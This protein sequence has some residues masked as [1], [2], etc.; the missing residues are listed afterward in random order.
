MSLTFVSINPNLP[1]GY[2]IDFRV[3]RTLYYSAATDTLYCRRSDI[4]NSSEQPISDAVT[5]S[6]YYPSNAVNCE[7]VSTDAADTQTITIYYWANSADDLPSVQQVTLT[8]TTPVA[9]PNAV[10]RGRRMLVTSIAGMNQGTVTLYESGNAANI[11]SA[12]SPN[13][14]YS[15]D[16]YIYVPANTIAILVKAQVLTNATEAK[17]WKITAYRYLNPLVPS[18]KLKVQEYSVNTAV[19]WDVDTQPAI[20]SNTTYELACSEPSGTGGVDGTVAY[21]FVYL[22]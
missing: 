10:F 19:S 4:N 14:G 3:N 5:T 6:Y 9:V 1:L 22:K 13:T 20:T 11:I 18:Y 21:E 2:G 15:M 8:G 16:S 17:D 7:I 12:M